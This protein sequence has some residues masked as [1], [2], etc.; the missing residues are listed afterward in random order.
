MPFG[1]HYEQ[2]QSRLSGMLCC[3]TSHPHLVVWGTIT[4]GNS[5]FLRVWNPGRSTCLEASAGK[6]QQ[7]G[8]SGATWRLLH[9]HG[10][11]RA[12]M[13][14][15]LGSAGT[16][17]WNLNMV[18]RVA[19]TPSQHGRYLCAGGS[20]GAPSGEE[21]FQESRGHAASPSS[22]CYWLRAS[23]KASPSSRSGRGKVTLQ[24]SWWDE[25]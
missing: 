16:V 22:P 17:A 1:T 3:R 11:C 20:Q 19:W 24:R 4:G 6:T 21:E 18:P 14:W 12:G 7:W 13:S 8:P 5:W 9:S 25:R 2:T 23:P 10:C 15:R